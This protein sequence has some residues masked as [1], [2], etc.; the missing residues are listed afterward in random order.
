M[1]LKKII[2]KY[3]DK[4]DDKYKPIIG[5]TI[6]YIH[7]SSIYLICIL[8]FFLNPKEILKLLHIGLL[9]IILFFLNNNWCILSYIEKKLLNDN[10]LFPDLY[11]YLLKLDY[12]KENRLIISIAGFILYQYILY[13]IYYFKNK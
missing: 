13:T 5:K 8:V 11:L 9:V 4:I 7:F 2:N 10:I 12:T 6:R 3:I 1:I